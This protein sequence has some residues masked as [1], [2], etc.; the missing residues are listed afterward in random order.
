M[1]TASS[2]TGVSEP[3]CVRGMI[4]CSWKAGYSPR[5]DVKILRQKGT[6][7]DII[8]KRV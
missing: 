6:D 2:S 4:I 7:T 1:T 8:Y 5:K 3:N